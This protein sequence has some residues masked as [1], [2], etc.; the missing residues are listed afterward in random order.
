MPAAA[1]YDWL[2]F[3]HI[4]VAMVWFGAAIL[5]VLAASRPTSESR[6]WTTRSSARFRG[7][8]AA[9]PPRRRVALRAQNDFENR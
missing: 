2:L 3:G 6:S 7:T 5:L 9:P 1:L 4:L 8:A